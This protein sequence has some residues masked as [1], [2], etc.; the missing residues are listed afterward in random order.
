[1]KCSVQGC[2]LDVY[3]KGLCSKHYTRLRRHG[4]VN[5]S[6]RARHGMCNTP[7]YMSYLGMMNRCYA[8][9]NAPENKLYKEKGIT[10]CEQW[11]QSF[12]TFISDMGNKPEPYYQLDRIDNDKGYFPENCRWVTPAENARNRG[13]NKITFQKAQKIKELL[14]KGEKIKEIAEKYQVSK[15]L[16]RDI[17]NNKTW[18][19]EVA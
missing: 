7:E 15:T 8:R 10:V 11:R 3:S 19:W 6:K 4:D 5:Y 16:I 18:K 1:M 9:V 14:A 2:L 17:K 13:N 12:V